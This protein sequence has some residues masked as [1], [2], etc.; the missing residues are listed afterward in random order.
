MQGVSRSYMDQAKELTLI[1]QELPEWQ[2]LAVGIGRGVLRRVDRA[3]NAF[4]RRVKAG[5]TPGYPRFKPSQRYTCIDI[6]DPTA[7]MVKHSPDTRKAYI[8][9]KGLPVIE[10]RLKQPLPDSQQLKTLR[11]LMQPN[12]VMVDLGYQV[13]REPLPDTGKAIGLDLGINNRIALSNGEM[14]ETRLEEGKKERRLRRKV[15]RAK[16]GSKGRRKKVK[17]LSRET[18]R[19]KVRNRNEVH[20]LTT[21]LIR[22]YDHIAMEG[23]VVP[24][25][26]RS[27]RGT[28]ENPG[29]NVAAKRELTRKIQA[30]TW[31]LIRQQLR[32]KAEWAGREFVEVDPKY[33]SRRC[34]QCGAISPQSEYRT[35]RCEICGQDYDRDTNAALNI[36]QKAFGE[37]T[38]VGLSPSVPKPEGL[39]Q[40]HS[41]I[42]LV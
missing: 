13:E 10:L 28:V 21:G 41:L 36:L 7:Y 18:R 32:Y 3:F 35:Y 11:I 6:A 2:E 29:V 33:T 15:A 34:N 40:N 25:M 42:A 31:G 22:E 27:A 1:R 24:N 5:Q 30:Q 37:R 8:K 9:V 38:G 19:K 23:L 4:F 12:G 26:T 16:K 20:R 14:V 17:A 39:T